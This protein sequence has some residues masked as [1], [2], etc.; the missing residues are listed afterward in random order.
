MGKMRRQRAT[1]DA[2]LLALIRRLVSGAVLLLLFL[3]RVPIGE[4]CLDIFQCQLHLIAIQPFGP[5]SK[6]KRC[7]QA[8]SLSGWPAG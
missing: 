4:R 2:P 8:T 7:F 1:V 6:R 5:L 3:F